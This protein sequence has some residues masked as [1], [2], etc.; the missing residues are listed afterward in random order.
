M[1]AGFL[2]FL[3]LHSFSDRRS[4][5][6]EL[7]SRP[8]RCLMWSLPR[9][10]GSE[11]QACSQ[12]SSR[13][14][15]L[16][17]TPE[18]ERDLASRAIARTKSRG[19]SISPITS[20]IRHNGQEPAGA[21]P[22]PWRPG[23]AG[24]ACGPGRRIT[25]VLAMPFRGQ[26]VAD[27]RVHG[28]LLGCWGSALSRGC[29]APVRRSGTD[30]VL[31]LLPQVRVPTVAGCSVWWLGWLASG[32]GHGSGGRVCRGRWGRAGGGI[33]GP[34][35]GRVGDRRAGW[36]GTADVAGVGRAAGGGGGPGS[37]G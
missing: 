11:G 5:W 27:G 15:W 16:D 8:P 31:W 2:N 14:S 20:A 1:R 25:L 18:G 37:S 21:V 33:A 10:W 7:L 3:R 30:A 26:L 32:Y 22:A 36:G 35:G 13:T 34:A 29:W 4:D 12:W 9:V 19:A 28:G 24:P 23:A 6:G 17:E